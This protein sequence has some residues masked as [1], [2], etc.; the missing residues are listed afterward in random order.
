MKNTNSEKQGV[1]S[2]KRQKKRQKKRSYKKPVIQA[3]QVFERTALA[4]NQDPFLNLQTDTKDNATTC[5]Y[6]DS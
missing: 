2:K 3:E 4:C 5:G 1:F 6:N